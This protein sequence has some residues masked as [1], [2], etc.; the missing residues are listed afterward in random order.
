MNVKQATY[1]HINSGE[2]LS[3]G[4]TFS[5]GEKWNQFHNDLYNTEY[6]LNGKDAN[7]W[8]LE[9]RRSGRNCCDGE[10]F[11]LVAQTIYS[12]AAITRELVFEEVRREIDENLPSRMKCLYVCKTLD[13]I[14]QWLDVFKRTNKQ[15]GQILQLSLTGKVF[16]GDASFILRQNISLNKKRQQA[17]SYWTGECKDGIDEYLFTGLAT[18]DEIIPL[19]KLRA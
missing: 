5:V 6:M 4:D 1:Y 16:H 11:K 13:E 14:R 7:E 9:A 8:L 3:V 15:P 18:V 19:D 17:I 2:P 12:D 10:V